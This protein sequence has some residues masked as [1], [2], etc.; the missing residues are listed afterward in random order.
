MGVTFEI[1]HIIP[2]ADGGKNQDQNLCLSCP[3]CNRYKAARTTA[4]KSTNY[5]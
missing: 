2:L 4:N 5:S 3:T 1:D